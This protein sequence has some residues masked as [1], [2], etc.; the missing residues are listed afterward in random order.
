MSRFRVQTMINNNGSHMV[1][2]FEK[3]QS[4]Y[5]HC[6]G[7]HVRDDQVLAVLD[8]F[9]RNEIIPGHLDNSEIHCRG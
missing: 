4:T 1:Q 3:S 5:E 9:A 2:S 8:S 6:E 7:E